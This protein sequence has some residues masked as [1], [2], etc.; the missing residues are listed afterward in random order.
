MREPKGRGR[1]RRGLEKEQKDCL[2]RVPFAENLDTR[3]TCW[4]RAPSLWKPPE[5]VPSL[6]D[7]KP[8]PCECIDLGCLT[9][10]I[11]IL[12]RVSSMGFQFPCM[13]SRGDVLSCGIESCVNEAE[14]SLSQVDSTPA[15]EPGRQNRSPEYLFDCVV[16]GVVCE[17]GCV[18]TGSVL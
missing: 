1:I 10:E 16:S 6:E 3:A 12:C 8:L 14:A 4:A 5:E 13:R 9:Q 15:V 18:I 7:P 2:P 17:S 11:D